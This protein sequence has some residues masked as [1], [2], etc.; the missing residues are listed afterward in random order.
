MFRKVHWCDL[1]IGAIALWLLASPA[2]LDFDLD[3]HPDETAAALN[4]Y[5]VGT[6]LLIYCLMS[7]WRQRDVGNE[8]LN[9]TFGTWLMVSPYV[10]AYSHWMMPTLNGLMTGLAVVA[11][12]VLDIRLTIRRV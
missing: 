9:I 8:M 2:A 5:V 4:H 10:L 6:G 7:A 12:A 11:L 3:Q 1:L